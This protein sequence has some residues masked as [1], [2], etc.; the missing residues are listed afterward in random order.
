MVKEAKGRI[1]TL[2]DTYE[3]GKLYGEGARVVLTGS[4]NAGKSTLFNLLLKEDR[5]IVSDVHGTTRDFIESKTVLD[6]IPVRLYDTAGLRDSIDVVEQEGIRRTRRLLSEAD[7]ILLMLDGTEHDEQSVMQHHDL[8]HDP[9][10]IV[11][12]NKTDLTDRKPLTGSYPL[13]A[14]RGEGFSALRDEMVMRLR[15]DAKR[16]DGQDVVI[17]SARQHDEL[18][19]AHGALDRALVLAGEEVPLDIV[20][21][22]LGE[23]LEALGTLTGEV[24]SADILE[25]IF[26]GFCVGK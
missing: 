2:L 13:S 8:L 11:V 23:A 18:V 20:V 24:A 1:E 7:L 5:S 17:E 16:P 14:K 25:K 6:G 12:W 26:S 22:E 4:T 15:K 10:C 9:R 3:I 19:R 21:V